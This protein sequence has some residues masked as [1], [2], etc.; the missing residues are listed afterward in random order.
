MQRSSHWRPSISFSF[1]VKSQ[2]RDCCRRTRPSR[3]REP[4]WS[5]CR[6]SSVTT[7]RRL[8]S[9]RLSTSRITIEQLGSHMKMA[10]TSHQRRLK[11]RRDCPS[12]RCLVAA[13]AGIHASLIARMRHTLK[14]ASSSYTKS[15]R[16]NTPNQ[17]I[18]KVKAKSGSRSR[19]LSLKHQS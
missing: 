12:V 11:A 14:T 6:S 5:G 3:A 13:T 2:T 18:M 7:D 17:K 9:Q 1:K 15:H 8:S 10:H 4:T 19:A 16:S